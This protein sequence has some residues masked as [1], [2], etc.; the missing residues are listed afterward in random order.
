[1][2]FVPHLR[3][4]DKVGLEKLKQLEVHFIKEELT[5]GY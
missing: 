5:N 3:D 1:M 4:D 2:R